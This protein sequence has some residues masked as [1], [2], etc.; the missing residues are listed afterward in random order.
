MDTLK[1][2]IILLSHPHLTR[3]LT[4]HSA[5]HLGST[6]ALGN[7][8]Y[9]I[10]SCRNHQNQL[11]FTCQCYQHT[12]TVLLWASKHLAL[13]HNIVCRTSLV[14]QRLRICLSM[15]GTRVRSLV[16]EA[17]ACRRAANPMH[18]NY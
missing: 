9:P 4:V 10:P 18:H 7:I 15:E 2:K 8:F 1:K 14:V 11:A 3:L 13:Y 6:I 16:Q 5:W 12:F 17:F